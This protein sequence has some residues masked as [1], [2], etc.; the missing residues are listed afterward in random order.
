MRDG[1]PV[2]PPLETGTSSTSSVSPENLADMHWASDEILGP[3]FSAGDQ[4]NDRLFELNSQLRL[5][6]IA[7]SRRDEAHHRKVSQ[8]RLI[9]SDG[10][11]VSAGI[12]SGALDP[13][14]LAALVALR[15]WIKRYVLQHE[16]S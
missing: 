16:R 14:F 2:T 6:R 1:T 5:E 13:A 7:R 15:S 12:G 4:A 10:V 3:L 9:C 8:L 11:V